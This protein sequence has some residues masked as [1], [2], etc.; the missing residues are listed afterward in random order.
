MI[1][2]KLYVHA[3]HANPSIT[4]LSIE[5]RTN[6]KKSKL[7]I[8][9]FRRSFTNLSKRNS[10]DLSP[11][12]HSN[13]YDDQN[14][15]TRKSVRSKYRKPKNRRLS[16]PIAISARN[17]FATL[18]STTNKGSDIETSSDSS[19]TT[20]QSNEEIKDNSY[21]ASNRSIN[22]NQNNATSARLTSTK[23]R[24][25]NQTMAN[26]LIRSTPSRLDQQENVAHL[27]AASYIGDEKYPFTLHD[28]K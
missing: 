12:N 23:F 21:N 26:G 3:Y 15:T 11:N 1:I 28:G 4:P 16:D 27:Q 7:N 20:F 5:D 10:I 22:Y 13:T 8:F 24:N 6:S 17:N 14:D 19:N 9:K 25:Q 18:S 2:G